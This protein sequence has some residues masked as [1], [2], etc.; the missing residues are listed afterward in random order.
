MARRPSQPSGC[1]HASAWSI[2]FVA[3]A[4]AST[5]GR[6]VAAERELPPVTAVAPPSTRVD[7]DEKDPTGFAT[8]VEARRGE[9]ATAQELVLASP[10]VG[11]RDFG[12]NQAATLSVRGSTSDQVVVLLDGLPLNS[13]A[14]GGTD[15]STLP[16]AMLERLT[17]ARGSV[18]A[19][20][21][22]GALG[23]ALLLETRRP[24]PGDQRA[25]G[26]LTAGSFGSAEGS[27]GAALG[28][29]KI[30]A[31]LLGYGG[32]SRGNFSYAYDPQ[33]QLE[34]NALVDRVRDNNQAKR[35]GG[36]GRLVFEGSGGLH[37]ELLLEG[38]GARRG[39]PGSAQAPT[40]SLWQRDGRLSAVGRISRSVGDVVLELRG[41]ARRSR[42]SLGDG[43]LAPGPQDDSLL[44]TELAGQTLLGRHALEL[45]GTVGTERLESAFHGLHSRARL[46]AFA[47]DE[48]TL[49][50]LSLLPA[51]RVERVGEASGLAPKLGVSVP[52][53]PIF[54]VKANAGRS[55]RA[56]SF[57][58]L[59]LEQGT[60]TPNPGLRP[61]T[62]GFTDLGVVAKTGPLDAS[63]SGFYTLYQEL[64]LYELYAPLRA[65]PVNFGIAE[66]WGAE[67]DVTAAQ[68][69]FTLAAGYTLAF[70]ANRLDD[71]RYFDKDLPYHP[72]H[73]V[74]VRGALAL[75]RFGSFLELNGQTAQFINRTNTDAAA[76]RA[77][78]NAGVSF[79]VDRG[80]GFT[81]AAVMKNALDSQDQDLYGHP[82]PGRA[83][84]ARARLEFGDSPPAA[85]STP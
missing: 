77:R 52:L 85:R 48:I 20:Y 30:S 75:G 46:A 82:L 5:P 47:S 78:L 72:R 58:E 27:A 59:Y 23:G 32:Y 4:A 10:G 69:P 66:V 80:S 60:L 67:L 24:A 2:A 54:S 64:I 37:G 16:S 79:L 49:P 18:G 65:K 50:W 74:H 9:A 44:F 26:D 29:K 62:A 19:R 81:L 7:A 34:G 12:L 57:G 33:P 21:G 15:L 3:L 42:L 63:L 83:L 43:E 8:V 39:L 17:V 53:G 73:R 55:F 51:V 84:Y 61:E 1:R 68:G 14:G 41:G 6:A 76:G 22:A 28:G 45:G 31:L 25:F 56:P 35:A 70:S 13:S 71:E 40:P 38:M 11:V 36:L